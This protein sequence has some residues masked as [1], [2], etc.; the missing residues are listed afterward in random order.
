MKNL[1]RLACFISCS[2]FMLASEGIGQSR[3]QIFVGARPLGLG[4]AYTAV[5][6]D[7]NSVYWNP[8][9]MPTLRRLEFNS[10]Y[11][12][13]YG[14]QGLKN[15]YLSFVL[16]LTPRYY[17][18]ASWNH[19]GFDDDELE[20]YTNKANLSFGAK[21]FGNLYLGANLK[22]L[23]TDARLDGFSEG[24]ANGI[25]FDLGALYA[26]PLKKTGFLKQINLGLMAHDVGGTGITYGETNKTETVLPQN[27]RFGLSIY[28]KEEISCKW[29]ALTDPL[30]TFEFDDRFHAGAETWLMNVLGLRA[31]LQR[32]F[33]TDESM[34][35]SFGG[36]LRL[37]YVSM[38]VDYAYVIPPTLLPTHVFS[39]SFIPNIS[40]IKITGIRMNDVFASFY[41]SYATTKIGNVSIRNDSDKELKITMKVSV[42]GLTETASQESF[43]L[44]ANEERSSFFSAIFSKEIMNIKEPEFRQVK[45]RV[46]YKIRN[47]DKFTE[48]AEKFRLYGRGAVTWDDPGKAV[49]Y[50]TKLDHLVEFFAIGATKDLPYRPE[51]EL[52]NLYTAAA[53][54]DAMGALGIKYHE[55][56]ENP[57]SAIPKS[58]HSID[59]I[60]YPAQLLI[61]R[62]GDCDDLTVLYASLLEYSGIRTA[63]ISTS[64]H[65]TLM[66]DTG[67]HEQDWGVLPAGDSLVV[68][69]DKTLWIPV[70]VTDIGKSFQDAWNTGGKQY[71]ELKSDPEFNVTSVRDFEGVYISA[72]PEEIQGILPDMPDAAELARWTKKDYAYIDDVHST[73]SIRK[74]LVKIQNDPANTRWINEL[75][76]IYAQQ[77]SIHSS[78]EQFLNILSVQPGNPAALNNLA[79]VY[80]ISGRFAES[81][82]YYSMASEIS[83]D[84]PG[85]YLNLSILYQLWRAEGPSDSL[86]L[87]NK[88]EQ[89]LLKAFDLLKGD[90]SKS[91]DLL[92]ILDDGLEL[93]QKADFKS[94]IK[95]QSSTIKKFIRDN[96]KKY[97]FNRSVAGAQI[98]RR[99]VKRGLDNARSYILWWSLERG[100]K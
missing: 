3:N 24:K 88:S 91:F 92:G 89:N 30:L 71:D 13:L 69:R 26:H 11:A 10:M 23:D 53:L 5:A 9:G 84:E 15:F 19:F 83:K 38:Q 20:Y 80:C 29:F 57:F 96:S 36:S 61:D 7:G 85:I 32:D 45:V 22:Y 95:S 43:V 51:I 74:Y 47:E 16:P 8:A 33:H 56:P 52:G 64:N 65:I 49:A 94:W 14:I 12:D 66:F 1:T 25:G 67:I 98:E 81:E 63:L 46:E 73:S 93:E 59:Y 21:A 99:G 6:D 82:K 39:V 28:P 76:I 75:G 42:P 37:P 48:S 40:P 55:D 78:E 68:V 31:G 97:L 72:L 2:L 86:N 60:K 58:Q 44:G 87:Q 62:Q 70:E 90:A 4:E 50:V 35:Y 77:D 17:L 34:T 18:G 79:N 27:I 100:S 41:K 54:F